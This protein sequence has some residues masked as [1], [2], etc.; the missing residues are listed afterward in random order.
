MPETNNWAAA[1]PANGLIVAD[2]NS[3]H[4]TV[5]RGPFNQRAALA[6][7]LVSTR[8]ETTMLKT[9]ALATALALTSSLAFAQAGGNDAG[10]TFP[11]TPAPS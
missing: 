5:T 1:I 9:L 6:C 3:S 11:K 8:E 10:A 2:G 4:Q 7:F